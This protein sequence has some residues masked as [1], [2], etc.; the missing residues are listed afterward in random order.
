MGRLASR[1]RRPGP[2]KYWPGALLRVFTDQP[3][4]HP[5]PGP[6]RFDRV[7]W[8]STDSYRL[9]IRTPAAGSHRPFAEVLD[10]DAVKLIGTMFKAVPDGVDRRHRRA[11]VL[12]ADGTRSLYVRTVEGDFTNSK[13]FAPD[14]SDGD[15]AT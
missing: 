6:G 11:T 4:T 12:V 13:S 3:R 15:T 2:A 14:P 8:V 10:R 7:G 9:T 5:G 1:Q